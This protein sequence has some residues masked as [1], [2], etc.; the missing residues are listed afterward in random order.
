LRSNGTE[1]VLLGTRPFTCAEEGEHGTN[2]PWLGLCLIRRA[3]RLAHCI[4]RR[5]CS[6]SAIRLSSTPRPTFLGETP[7]VR[8]Q[9]C[10]F[11]GSWL[12]YR[13]SIRRRPLNEKQGSYVVRIVDQRRG[14]IENMV[15]HSRIPLSFTSELTLWSAGK[16]NMAVDDGLGEIPSPS[17]YV[18]SIFRSLRQI[19]A[20]RAQELV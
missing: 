11:V 10:C 4:A 1:K 12:R 17:L 3:T 19:A 2:S 8:H 13:F 15:W 7:N 6:N 9:T 20:W 5:H 14:F 18:P 16:K